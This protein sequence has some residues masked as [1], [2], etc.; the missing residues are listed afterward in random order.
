MMKNVELMSWYT[1]C[2]LVNDLFG[3]WV[4]FKGSQWR[5]DVLFRV[6]LPFIAKFFL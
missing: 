5:L 3:G 6:S 4:S 2:S 1:D